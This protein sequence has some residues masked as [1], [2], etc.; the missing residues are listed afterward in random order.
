MFRAAIWEM[1][2]FIG[3]DLVSMRKRPSGS[4]DW[5]RSEGEFRRP[6]ACR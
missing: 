2:N 3:N 4:V 5:Q 6:S 1:L